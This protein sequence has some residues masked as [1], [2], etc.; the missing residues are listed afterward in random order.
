[1]TKIF[2]FKN[3]INES[4]LK[5]CA[6]A[7]KDGKLVIF[8][9]ETVYGIGADATNKE[10]CTN[11]FVAKGRAQDNPLIVHISDFDDLD[12]IVYEP[13]EEE[14]KLMDAFMPGPFTLI[15]KKKNV[16]PE[17]VSA[18]LPT[19]GV[20]MPSN[21]IA[22]DLIKISGCPIAAPSANKSGKPSGTNV[23]DIFDEFNNKVE[24]MIDGGETDIGLESTVVKIIDGMPTILRPG[25][26]T[27]E[28][29]LKVCGKVKVSDNVF[30]Q[31]TGVVESPGMKYRHYAPTTKCLLI[32]S[33]NND[34]L[35]KEI[36]KH[37]L[38]KTCIIGSKENETKFTCDYL[39]YGN[40][41]NLDEIS[42]NIFTLLRKADELHDELIIIEGVDKKGLGI[43][44]MNR[45]IRTCEYNFIEVK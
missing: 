25:K 38:S 43:A 40:K 29:I 17:T 32:Y 42:H 34:I 15:L 20:R 26:I 11:I 24:Y 12:K 30:K 19:I 18:N 39:S 2:D 5:V 3:G 45:L 4:E 21:K 8:P 44:I 36:G 35:I 10:A 14:K 23:E 7:I 6:K 27:P 16:I 37:V 13:S 22:H 33:P 41:N 9:T 31:A 28:D 1:M